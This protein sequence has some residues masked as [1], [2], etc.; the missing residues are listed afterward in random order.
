MPDFRI[1]CENPAD[2]NQIWVT[3]N[4]DTSTLVSASGDSIVEKLEPKSPYLPAIVT[5]PAAPTGKTAT[6]RVLKIQ[7]GLSC[8]YECTY[9]S[10]RFVPRSEETN[11]ES[12][13]DFLAMVDANL[14]LGDGSGVKI[15][16][17]GGEPFVYW[18]TMKPLAERLREKLPKAHF[19][20][21]T[22]GSLLTDE[23]VD[24]LLE[25]GFGMAISHDGPGMKYRGPD[26][27]DDPAVAA[28]IRRA[29]N[30]FNAYGRNISFNTMLHAENME[31]APVIQFFRDFLGHDD[32]GIGEGSVVDA[33][34]DDG[35]AISLTTK[36]QRFSFRRKALEEMM[37]VDLGKWSI[38]GTKL[39]AFHDS[40]ISGRPLTSIGQKCGM[41]Q[42]DAVAV[43]LRGNV[44]TC[45]NVSAVSA[46]PAGDS[47]NIGHVN[48]MGLVALKTATHLSARNDCPRCPVVHL[49]G[50]SCMFLSG[51][52]WDVSCN[53]AYT[54]N[55][56]YFAYA[57][58]QLTGHIPV[59]IEADWLPDDRKDIF[60]AL[61]EHKE[62]KQF[63]I[64]VVAA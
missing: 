44:L 10:Q 16:F 40:L 19:S 9:C 42:R 38:V 6:V 30:L 48:D 47:H 37:S 41:D 57:L 58:Y 5:T 59:W 21:I 32:F 4:S 17:W 43:D 60:G 13:D 64:P 1:L 45:Q 28:A 25:L 20:V 36:A 3:Y 7:L 55:V 63:P 29:F 46:N 62:V 56:A 39:Q 24:W 22:N 2:G 8:N 14:R 23:K 35:A 34:D 33:Y 52:L 26:P 11:P 12:I 27:L 54:E 53:N 49:C 51:R 18:K 15:E 61:M 50:G 31:R